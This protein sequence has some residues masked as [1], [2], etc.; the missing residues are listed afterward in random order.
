M[1]WSLRVL[2]HRAAAQR[3]LLATVV[4]VALVGASLLG[5]FA[6]LLF[7]SENRA[8]DTALTARRPRPRTS[9]SILTLDRGGPLG[10][11]AAGRGVPR[12]AAGR[13]PRRRGPSGSRRRC[14]GSSARAST[15]PPMAYL[16][17][18]PRGPGARH[19]R[20][21]HLA[22]DGG[23]RRGPGPGR[24]SRRSRPSR[25]GWTVGTVLPVLNSTTQD[26][27]DGRRHRHPR[28]GQAAQPVDPRPA[29]GRPARPAVPGAGQLRLR[30]HRRLGP[31]RRRAGR[32][33]GAGLGRHGQARRV[34][35]A[36]G[37]R[38]RAPSTALREPARRRP[39]HASSPA[40]ERQR[41]RR[42]V[43]LPPRDHDR[44]GAEQPGGDPGQ[45]RHRRPHARR[46]RGHR[47]AAGS[48]PARRP[49]GARSRP[50]CRRAARRAASCCALAALEAAVVA[51]VTTLVSPWLAGLLFQAIT[52]VGPLAEAGLHHDPGR[53]PSL[54]I[55]CAVSSFVLAAVLLGPLLRRR[56][57]VVDAEQQLVRQDRRGGL[58][59]SGA[60]LALL[61][62]AGL[63]V[64]QLRA[65]RSPVAESGAAQLDPVLVARTRP[66]CCSPAPS[67]RCGCCPWSRAP[68]SGWRPAA[69]RSSPRSP[70]GRSAGGRAGR[71]ARCSCSRS[72]WRSARSPSRSSAR[73][74]RPRA[75]RWTSPSG[76]TCGWTAWTAPASPRRARS[77]A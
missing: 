17:D 5:T 29:A 51:L 37:Q 73:G 42:P 34:P 74:G 3:T 55:T 25:Y 62:L 11:I 21:R 65:Y 53:P 7:S 18:Q 71:P 59:R 35:A 46:A 70:R 66:R 48:A 41:A 8:L 39:G 43:P 52:A 77:T 30:R 60:D 12:R 15:V 20:G 68:A 19:A 32:A 24:S 63:A 75:T 4:A 23:R 57:S 13:R 10:A 16:A 72:R 50:S 2:R 49:P 26:E 38:R 67:S 14:T 76:P 27:S 22:D 6:L 64:W 45:P 47:A 40:T 31:V 36:G 69:G 44:R 28:A 54:W 33:D 56:G 61:V 1:G 58:A 9:T